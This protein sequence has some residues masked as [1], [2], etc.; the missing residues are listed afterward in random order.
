MHC[1]GEC[2]TTVSHYSTQLLVLLCCVAPPPPFHLR[3][4][5]MSG[6][7]LGWTPTTVHSSCLGVAGTC[8]DKLAV[9]SPPHTV[10][11]VPTIHHTLSNCLSHTVNCV[12]SIVHC[13]IVHLIL[14]TVYPAYTSYIV[15]L[16]VAYCQL[17]TQHIIMHCQIACQT[18]STVCLA[19][20]HHTLSDSL[21]YTVNCVPSLFIT[22]SLSQIVK[23]ILN[24]YMPA[25]HYQIARRLSTVYPTYTSFIVKLPVTHS[26]LVNL[27]YTW[28]S[29][30]VRLPIPHC[31]LCTQHMH[32]CHWWWWKAFI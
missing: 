27:S 7:S 28:L 2:T 4:S 12:P 17:C 11:Y 8:T 9:S 6:A 10:N 25:M 32:A 14:S 26:Q 16:P 29:R 18:P 5:C 15:R 1:A 30:I 31:Q 20:I 13:E 3:P 19:Y 24:I 23:C 22:Q 21:S